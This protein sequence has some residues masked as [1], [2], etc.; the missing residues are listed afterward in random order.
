MSDRVWI[1]AP[2]G[3]LHP[4]LYK[5]QLA[6]RG[7]WVP[8]RLVLIDGDRDEYGRLLS[9]QRYDL[10]V[11]GEE[12]LVGK[13]APLVGYPINEAE[14]RHLQTVREYDKTYTPQTAESREPVNLLTSPLPF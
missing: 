10:T 6:K 11:D 8:V 7:P 9:D 14:F 12:W 13:C 1:V 4:G 3:E 2:N 5:A